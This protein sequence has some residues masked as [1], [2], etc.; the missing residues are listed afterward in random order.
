M[1]PKRRLA[2]PLLNDMLHDTRLDRREYANSQ[3]ALEVEKSS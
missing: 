3:N 1:S 2:L